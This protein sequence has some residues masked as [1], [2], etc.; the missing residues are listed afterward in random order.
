MC[1]FPPLSPP[2][3]SPTVEMDEGT[4]PPRIYTLQVSDDDTP[5]TIEIPHTG[6][7]PSG[8]NSLEF[9]F[10]NSGELPG[11]DVA[12]LF[13]MVRDTYALFIRT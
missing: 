9:D 11:I 6:Q 12:A 4:P 8:T 3:P 1:P 2:S 5:T 7:Q 13:G 10:G